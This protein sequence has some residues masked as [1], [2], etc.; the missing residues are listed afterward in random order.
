MFGSRA[1][2][3]GTALFHFLRTKWLRSAFG[4]ENGAVLF[5]VWFVESEWSHSNTVKHRY[6]PTHKSYLANSSIVGS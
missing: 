1:K 2:K 4:S 5:F 3:N 6:S